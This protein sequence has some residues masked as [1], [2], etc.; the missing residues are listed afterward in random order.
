LSFPNNQKGFSLI[1]TVIAIGILATVVGSMIGLQG[2]VMRILYFST[3][4]QKASLILNSSQA[5]LEYLLNQKGFQIF[6]KQDDP[7]KWTSQLNPKFE[8]TFIVTDPN[9][10]MSQFLLTAMQLYY[11]N[12]DENSN[13][14]LTKMMFTAIG[15]QLDNSIKGDVSVNLKLTTSW[16]NRATERSISQSMYLINTEALGKIN[17]FKSESPAQ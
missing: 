8:N 15:D 6:V 17:L 2:S 9:V 12:E 7:K 4:K 10:K 16:K 13:S 14:E 3:E 1:E 5:Q 11:T